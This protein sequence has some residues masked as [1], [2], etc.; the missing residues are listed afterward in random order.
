MG[1]VLRSK[2]TLEAWKE[3]TVYKIIARELLPKSAFGAAVSRMESTSLTSDP[4]TEML[5]LGLELPPVETPCHVTKQVLSCQ[6]CWLLWIFMA[7]WLLTLL[8]PSKRKAISALVG[9]ESI[10]VTPGFWVWFKTAKSWVLLSKTSTSDDEVPV[11]FFLFSFFKIL[12]QLPP[13]TSSMPK[14][15]WHP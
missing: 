5:L 1:S 9:L 14:K 12:L 3:K 7:G 11:L 8:P 6:G 4:P 15:W 10:F 2:F 13:S